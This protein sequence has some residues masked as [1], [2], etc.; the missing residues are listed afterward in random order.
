[1]PLKRNAPYRGLLILFLGI[2]LFNFFCLQSLSS[3]EKLSQQ[4]LP[5]LLQSSLKGAAVG[6]NVVSLPDKNPLFSYNSQ[7]IYTVASNMKL[8]T[9]A[10]AL[11]YLGSDYQFSTTLFCRGNIDPEGKLWGD[12]IVQGGGDPNLSG[13]FNG[14]RTTAVLEEWAE[15]IVKAGIKEISG[16]IIAD[17]SFFDRELIH[18]GWPKDQLFT[19]YSAPISALSFNDNCVDITLRPT[20]GSGVKVEVNPSNSYLRILNSCKLSDSTGR[21]RIHVHLEPN[22]GKIHLKGEMPT[23][24]ESLTYS[25]PVD[26]P[27]LFLASVFREI[28][29]SKGV[30]VVG[31]TIVFEPEIDESDQEWTP[32][33]CTTSSMSQAVMVANTRSQ[34]FYAEQILKT[35]GAEVK[36]EGSFRAGLEVIQELMLKLGYEPVEYQVADGS[37][38]CRDNR[39]SPEMITDLLAYMYQHKEKESFIS[40]LAVSGTTGSLQ[41]RLRGSSFKGRI[42]AKTG[43]ISRVCCLSGY[44]ETEG[45]DTLAFSILVN[46][47]KVAPVTIKEF[48]DSV[49]KV[50]IKYNEPKAATVENGNG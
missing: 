10:A 30:K 5:L 32:L 48:Q 39:F 46:N 40:S 14:G 42:R 3:A 36:G 33:M 1:M 4:L 23:R 18:P 25:V 28:L 20:S 41:K 15:A 49:C 45:G 6:I 12:V 11:D 26:N 27:P 9:T 13:R 35:L 2:F 24:C 21:P 7:E 31:E 8:F 47:F 17:D 43:Y 44:V 19:W 50:L 22:T 38:L 16:N 34:N 29:K 37:G